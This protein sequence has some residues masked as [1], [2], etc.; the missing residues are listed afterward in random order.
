MLL[1]L[2]LTLLPAAQPPG[3]PGGPAPPA[4]PVDILRE[5]HGSPPPGGATPPLLAEIEEAGRLVRRGIV[6]HSLSLPLQ[7]ALDL[8]SA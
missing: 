4:T 3:V 1:L 7:P 2:S 5:A 8:K 6:A